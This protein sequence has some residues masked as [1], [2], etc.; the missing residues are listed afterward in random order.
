MRKGTTRS[1]LVGYLLIVGLF[2]LGVL[3]FL[4]NIHIEAE[5]QVVELCSTI[6]FEQ[7]DT[8]ILGIKIKWPVSIKGEIDTSKPG[9]YEV[10][11][12]PFLTRNREK[13]SFT[14]VDNQKPILKLVGEQE[15]TLK[16]I[17]EYEEFGCTA[18][19]NYDGD[20]TE[21]VETR[22][23]QSATN[24]Y[25]VEYTVED[26]SR[27][28]TVVNRIVNIVKGRVCLTFDDGPSYDITPQVLDVLKE[29][30]IKATFFLVGYEENKSN[31]VKRIYEEGHTIGLHGYSHAYSEIYTSIEALMENF[32]KIEELVADTTNGYH[33]KIIRFPG[34]AS[35][36]VSKKYCKGIMSEAVQVVEDRGYIFY[37][38]NVD[39]GDAGSAWTSEEIYENV[40]SGIRPG[41]LNVVLMHDSGGH[42][43]TLEALKMIIEYCKENAYSFEAITTETRP[44]IH[45]NV[46]N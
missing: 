4:S 40:I 36:T 42:D 31:L 24:K 8:A 2:V 1:P 21:K 9:E 29:H 19:D 38:W 43:E 20:I 14:V 30:D 7:I 46:S 35:N 41:R 6:D 11:C 10:E 45:H 34:G 23:L 17:E 37:D 39:S 18:S 28:V 5:N 13:V 27:N 33:S 22:I 12:T 26:S 15:I 16:G 3:G 44:I 25:L 32:Q